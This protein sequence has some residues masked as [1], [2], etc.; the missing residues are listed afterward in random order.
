MPLDYRTLIDNPEVL[1]AIIV[2]ARRERAR[3]F[4]RLV[5]APLFALFRRPKP[6]A[7]RMLRS[8]AYC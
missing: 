6:R 4:H 7:S 1:D 2:A 3:E 5:M 8:Q